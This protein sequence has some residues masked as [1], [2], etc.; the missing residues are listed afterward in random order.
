MVLLVTS[1]FV[2]LAVALSPPA[3]WPL[4][5]VL[6]PASGWSQWG[7]EAA[8][9]RAYCS[10]EVLF[11]ESP[12]STRAERGRCSVGSVLLPQCLGVSPGQP[13]FSK[14][15]R[16]QFGNYWGSC[17]LLQK[18]VYR[19]VWKALVRNGTSDAV[20]LEAYFQT[21][22]VEIQLIVPHMIF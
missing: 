12:R 15:L 6:F 11:Q 22:W 18:M 20:S 10:H 5:W 16:A 17:T 4:V 19:N 2:V 14:F 8:A 3:S 9:L 1:S 21:Q 13:L 7:H